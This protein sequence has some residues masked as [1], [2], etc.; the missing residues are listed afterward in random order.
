MV[1]KIDFHLHTIASIK[2][3][4][5]I[6]SLDW[7]RNYV[8]EMELDAIAI[9]NHDLFDKENFEEITVALDKVK[10]YPGIE[11]TLDV[12]HVNI[13]FPIDC[14]DELLTFSDWLSQIHQTQSDSITCEQYVT[15]YLVGKKVFTYLNLGRAKE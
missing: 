8:E 12:G 7:L 13:I 6:F 2:D 3:S 15:N 11:L 14:I 10:V 9:T 5:F 4:E 1:Q